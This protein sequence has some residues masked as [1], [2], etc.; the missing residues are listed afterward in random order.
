MEIG[1]GK[2]PLKKK[3]KVS[4]CSMAS[5]IPTPSG[6]KQTTIDSFGKNGKNHGKYIRRNPRNDVPENED[7][8]EVNLRGICIKFRLTR[9]VVFSLTD[10]TYHKIRLNFVV[11]QWLM[12]GGVGSE[13]VF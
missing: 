9:I 7:P 1:R 5:S 6:A 8:I 11:R 4:D 13:R 10:P 2:S 3:L 12:V